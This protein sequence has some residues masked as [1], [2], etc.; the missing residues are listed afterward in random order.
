M[1]Q[2]DV[3]FVENHAI[4]KKHGLK[5]FLESLLHEHLEPCLFPLDQ[6]FLFL[7]F[8]RDSLNAP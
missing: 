7:H 1:E 4:L 3:W 6:F 2:F 8:K 5:K